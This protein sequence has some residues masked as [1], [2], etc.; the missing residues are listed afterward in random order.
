[1]FPNVY[2]RANEDAARHLFSVAPGLDS[3]VV[4]D[5]HVAAQVREAHHAARKCGA[6]GPILDRLFESAS[7]TSKR[8]R[9][10]TSVSSGVTTI[11]GAAIAAAAR[12]PDRFRTVACRW[13]A[14]AAPRPRLR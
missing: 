2:V 4:G 3:I 5:T 13:S 12:S 7:S 8:V 10:Q 9:A 11:P 1:L 14:R 6:T